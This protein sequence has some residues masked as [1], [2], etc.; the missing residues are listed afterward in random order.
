MTIDAGDLFVVENDLVVRT[1]KSYTITKPIKFTDGTSGWI[2][3]DA[4]RPGCI[5][6]GEDEEAAK[7]SLSRAR[8]AYDRAA[9]EPEDEETDTTGE[10]FSDE[11]SIGPAW[12]LVADGAGWAGAEATS[13]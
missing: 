8:I 7:E 5:G 10:L 6:Y 11:E 4:S 9:A 12:D 2:A 13:F 1:E 3:E